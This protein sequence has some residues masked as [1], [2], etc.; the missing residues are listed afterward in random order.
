MVFKK[1]FVVVVALIV[2]LSVGFVS[3][4]QLVKE[5]GTP[6]FPYRGVSESPQKGSP[7][8]ISGDTSGEKTGF[9]KNNWKI[10]SLIVV[11]IIILLIIY[12]IIKN[13]KSQRLNKIK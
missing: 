8:T 1:V 7:D 11:I 3:A 5:D 10:I 2:M 13:K 12:F 4:S 6:I 9:L